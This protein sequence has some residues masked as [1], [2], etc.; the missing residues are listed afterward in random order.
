MASLERNSI[1]ACRVHSDFEVD[2]TRGSSQN[3]AES[4]TWRSG[5]VVEGSGFEN[6]R[7]RKAT[8]GSNPLSSA[9]RSNG[10]S[11]PNVETNFSGG[12][13]NLGPQSL[14]Y[15]LRSANMTIPSGARP[16]VLL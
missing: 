3:R 12:R 14:T 10:V 13:E 11:V 15:C 6:R 5:R 7:S 4:S 16:V 8:R 9:T 2:V 1:P